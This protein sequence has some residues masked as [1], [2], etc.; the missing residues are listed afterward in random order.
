MDMNVKLTPVNAHSAAAV[1]AGAAINDKV[2]NSPVTPEKDKTK[3]RS[4][5][6]EQAVKDI[7]AFIDSIERNLKFSIDEESGQVVVKVVAKASGELIR[8]MPSEEALE[9]AR[10]LKEA[11][12]S[13]LLLQAKV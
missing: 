13:R 9:L 4:G 11:S 10:N 12:D 6:V 7:Q 2:S 8:Q 1:Q 3:P 5:E